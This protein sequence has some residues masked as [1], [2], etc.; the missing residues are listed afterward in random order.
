MKKI[1]QFTL[2][3]SLLVFLSC[4]FTGTNK[5]INE[6]PKKNIQ[7][8]EYATTILN[9]I[10]DIRRNGCKCGGRIYKPVGSLKLNN[11]LTK[12]ATRHSKYMHRTNDFNHVDN[13][14]NDVL[15]RVI[16]TGYDW[17]AVGENIAYGQT[18]P[19]EVMDAWILS[20]SHCENMMDGNYKDLG[21]NKTG[22][23]WT[24]VLGAKM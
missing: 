17:S 22:E 19:R 14:G 1:M 4:A 21:I 12:A 10:N 13:R 24:M 8:E 2:M 6:E 18:S 11:L 3:G 16:K 5:T 15:K 20:P 9:L 23:Y 7:Q